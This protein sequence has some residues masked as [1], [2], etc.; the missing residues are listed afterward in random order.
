M[1]EMYNGKKK[2]EYKNQTG[3]VEVRHGV[4]QTDMVEVRL[5]HGESEGEKARRGE[6]QWS[7]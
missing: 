7:H 5:R 1:K 6:R 2:R 4:N 3:V